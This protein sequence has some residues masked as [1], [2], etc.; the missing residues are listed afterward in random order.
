MTGPPLIRSVSA[1][2]IRTSTLS[3]S[4]ETF[5]PST[6]R[7]PFPMLLNSSRAFRYLLIS[8]ARFGTTSLARCLTNPATT[9]FTETEKENAKILE[10]VS[11]KVAHYKAA[12]EVSHSLLL[13][14]MTK[15]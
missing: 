5:T 11:A 10:A 8:Q 3:K 1:N 6:S 15:R 2:R 13:I 14:H 7:S 4:P 9:W 12:Q